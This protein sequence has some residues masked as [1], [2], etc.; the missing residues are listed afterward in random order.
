M[1]R[2]LKLILA[3]CFLCSPALATTERWVAGQG[4]GLTW[5]NLCTTELN[6]LASNNAIVCS[7]I[8]ANGTALDLFADF[9]ISFASVTSGSGSPSVGIAIYPLNEDGSTYGD[10]LYG[11]AAAGPPSVQTCSIPA[12]P[13]A[14]A[15]VI[16][17]GNCRAIALPPG[18]FK[19]VV[20]NNLGV[21][22]ASTTNVV[23]YRTY[24]YQ[25]N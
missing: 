21:S 10:G 25:S 13:A 6:S 17:T 20:W 7:T 1:T 16:G 3:A 15:A 5:G 24:N 12:P 8:V 18:S 22:A 19:I 2:L 9:S 14:T 4:Q 23:A 11:S